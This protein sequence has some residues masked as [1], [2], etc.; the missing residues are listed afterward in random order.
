MMLRAS[1][2]QTGRDVDL[3]LINGDAKA[4]AKDFEDALELAEFAE[5]LVLRDEPRLGL[6]RQRLL[7]VA[8]PEVLVDTAGVAAN[9]QRMVRIADS[10]GIPI[11]THSRNPLN[12]A[13]REELNL[14][15]FHSAYNSVLL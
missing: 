15:R 2:Q 14:T 9:F 10:T 1:A 11:D 7:E 6:A 4:V 8:G 3:T 12:D 5:A 13:V